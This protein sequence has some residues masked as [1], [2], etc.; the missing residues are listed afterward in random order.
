MAIKRFKPTS[1]GRRQYETADFSDL[2]KV[3]P[4]KS[5]TRFKHSTSGRN[6]S[7]RITVRF[8]GGGHRRRYRIIDFKRNK[9]GV[10]A[11]VDSIQYDPNRSAR[12]ALLKYV[13]G[14][15]SYILAPDGLKAGDMVVSS[16]N[17]DIQPGNAMPLRYIPSG[18][19]IHAVELKIGKG[20]QLVRSAGTAAQLMAKDGDY[21][22]LRLPSGE[23]RKVHVN[24]RATI[25]QVSNSQ[26][27]RIHIGK[28]GRTRWL[29]RRPHNRGVTMNPVD[30]PMGGGEGRTSGG[31]HPCSPW[32]QLSKGLKTRHNKS[33]DKFIIR[34][35]GKK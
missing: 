33:S 12:I 23:V 34:R 18:T 8:R 11:K 29:G 32:G 2:A 24:C 17:A 21:A 26:H 20:A 6:N 27:A 15:K 35:R 5:L 16:R 7:G 9:I 30:H 22:Q 1:P 25:G 19:M 10:P 14:E 13:D 4:E 31:R 3:R 28:A